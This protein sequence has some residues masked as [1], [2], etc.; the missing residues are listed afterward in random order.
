MTASPGS[1]PH[2]IDPSVLW[3]EVTGP[4]DDARP[5]RALA[6]ILANK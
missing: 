5:V 3:G 1:S 2:P 6:K 4:S